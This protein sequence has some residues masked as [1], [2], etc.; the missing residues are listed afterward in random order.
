MRPCH[1]QAIGLLVVIASLGL[2]AT[3]GDGESL[4]WPNWMG[5]YFNGSAQ[6]HGIELVDDVNQAKL[7]WI[8]ED[9]ISKPGNR[10]PQWPTGGYCSPV[11]KEIPVE[12]KVS[13]DVWAGYPI[14]RG[15][16][17]LQCTGKNYFVVDLLSG[18]LV[19]RTEARGAYS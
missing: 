15:H 7:L 13:P 17:Y 9:P 2:Q 4:G 14:Y 18:N 3:D 8:S 1:P 10:D 19:V 12:K 11:V 6:D 16:L 5:P